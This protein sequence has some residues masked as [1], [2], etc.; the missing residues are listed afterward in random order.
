LYIDGGNIETPRTYYFD[1]IQGPPLQTTNGLED[2]QSSGFV[3][4]PNPASD[5]LYFKNV[6]PNTKVRIFDT[7]LRLIFSK[8]IPNNQ[9]S[10][11][12]LEKG[13][14]FIQINDQLKRLIK[15]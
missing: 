3:I 5:I 12:N 1:T 9:M 15:N 13:L 6:T 4:Y 7:N 11:E 10:I 2:L 8:N 14:Y